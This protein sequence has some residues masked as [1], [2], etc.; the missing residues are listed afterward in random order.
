MSVY[1]AAISGAGSSGLYDLET[2]TALRKADESADRLAVLRP[3][4]LQSLEA[5]QAAVTR[6]AQTATHPGL[7]E[8]EFS[9]IRRTVHSMAGSAAIYGYPALS[10]AARDAERVLEDR[11]I[12]R[13]ISALARLAD[14]ARAVLAGK[15]QAD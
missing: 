12:E 3:A 14:E 5:R 7:S 4:Y 15:P 1:D 9:D 13:W 6:A 10:E 2:M 11:A 8:T